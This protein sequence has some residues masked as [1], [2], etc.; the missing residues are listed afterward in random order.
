MV[1]APNA[2]ATM[3]GGDSLH[4]RSSTREDDF[5][6]KCERGHRNFI[7][8]SEE[9]GGPG[10][11]EGVSWHNA[12]Q[13]FQGFQGFRRFP[14]DLGAAPG[15]HNTA[16]YSGRLDG[17]T[18]NGGLV[19]NQT[20]ISLS[21]ETPDARPCEHES[22]QIQSSSGETFENH[23]AVRKYQ[24]MILNCVSEMRTYS[25]PD[26]GRRPPNEE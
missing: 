1:A 24:N 18:K 3:V 15:Q 4:G 2:S 9:G 5:S 16:H 6:L 21:T 11:S 20:R 12:G 26:F 17:P 19:A 23:R 13:G 22:V 25:V 8:V 7:E 14:R 10:G